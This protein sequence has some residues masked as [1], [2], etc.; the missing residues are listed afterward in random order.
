MGTGSWAAMGGLFSAPLES[1]GLCKEDV[2][3]LYRRRELVLCRINS[4]NARDTV[5]VIVCTEDL[6]EP[7]VEHDCGMDSV[8]RANTRMSLQEIKR[9]VKINFRDGENLLAGFF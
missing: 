1:G 4:C 6:G 9:P 3:K 7:V 5:K 2:S 8:A